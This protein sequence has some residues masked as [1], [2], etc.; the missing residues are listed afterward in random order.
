EAQRAEADRQREEA[1]RQRQRAVQLLYTARIGQAESALRLYDAAAARGLLDQCRPGP[2]EKDRRG[3][4]WSYLDQWCSPQLATIDLP[5][6]AQSGCLAVSPDGR[7]LAVG[8]WNPEAMI[9]GSSPPVPAYLISLPDG[10]VLRELP[11]HNLVVYSVSF[12]PDGKRLASSG[13]EGTI[14]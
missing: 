2:G 10:R 8:C 12:R 3:W 14:R 7:L 6:D 9:G 5:T 1:D 4:E 13:H 11:G